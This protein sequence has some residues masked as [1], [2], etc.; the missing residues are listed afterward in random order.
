MFEDQINRALKVKEHQN[1]VRE[2]FY[3]VKEIFDMYKTKDQLK[4]LQARADVD[5]ICAW[6][7]NRM[8][9]FALNGHGLEYADFVPE[10]Q[11]VKVPQL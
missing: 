10:A 4:T 11:G 3:C 9:S 8:K 5:T 2:H 7:Y 1:N 6:D